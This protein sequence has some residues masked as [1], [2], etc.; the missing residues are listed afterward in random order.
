MDAM[1]LDKKRPDAANRSQGNQTKKKWQEKSTSYH[2]KSM[3]RVS[4][5][6][7]SL[8]RYPVGSSRFLGVERTPLTPILMG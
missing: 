1:G 2:L 8:L 5:D 3:G 4:G 6:C 7:S